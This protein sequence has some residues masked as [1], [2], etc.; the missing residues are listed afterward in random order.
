M[1][2]KIYLRLLIFIITI[3]ITSLMVSSAGVS[4]A[5]TPELYFTILHTN[6]EH[7]ALL[8]S[9]LVDY[10]P[11]L[12]NPSRGGFAR[13]AQAVTEI[14]DRKDATQEPVVLVSAGD[15]LGGSPFAW[16]ALGGKAVELSLMMELGYDVVTIGNHEYDFGPDTLAEYLRVSGY[17][18]ANS[19]TALVGTNT[20]PPSGHPLGEMGIKTTHIQILSNGLKLGF[21]GIMG[22]DAV[23]VAPLAKPVEFGDQVEAAKAAVESLRQ[24][25]ADVIIA[26]NHA[27]LDE[28]KDLAKAVPGIHVIVSGHCHTALELPVLENGTIIVQTGE[29]LNNLGILELAYDAMTKTVRVRNS[30]TGT[31]HLLPLDDRIAIHPLFGQR[32]DVVSQELDALID[33][34]TEGRFQ[35]IKEILLTSDFRVSNEPKFQET[36]FG[37][38]V[39]DAMRFAAEDA[40]GDKVHFAFQG[41]GVIR[42]SLVAGNAP[43]SQGNVALLDLLDLVGL[44]AG[45]DKEP[46]YPLVSVYFTG[47]EVRRILEV[48]VLLSELMGDS[49]FLQVSGLRMTYDPKRAIIGRIPFKGT[50]IP[51]TRAVLSAEKYT[52]SGIQG[53]SGYE[54]LNRGDQELYHVISDYYN[55]AFLPMVGD[56][57]P[58]LGL[59]MKD[60]QGNPITVDEAIIYRNDRELKVWQAVVEYAASLPVGASGIAHVPDYYKSPAARLTIQQTIP[61][62]VYPLGSI[63]LLVTAVLYALAKRR[64]ARE[65]A[66]LE[67]QRAH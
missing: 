8:P 14:R 46:G 56:L 17:P 1:L 32:V 18:E 23:D 6:D 33:R 63:V 20:L 7:S 49:Y 40:T 67:K 41:S 21:F 30:E 16:L 55:A 9:P 51:S 11:E 59:V 25:G 29:L 54:P 24:Q 58:S 43:H 35:S 28:D 47:E 37:N 45:P 2:R 34:L 44:G 12:P 62:L 31:P 10:H 39:T 5:A 57:L 65:I 52:G 36:P 22:V 48:S 19:R 38:F 66:T 50:P 13:L 15:Y 4:Q 60:R 42:G 3:S 53:Q 26:L 27:G 61:L 64:R